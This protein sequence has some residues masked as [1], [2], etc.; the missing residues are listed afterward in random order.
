MEITK[1]ALE[2]RKKLIEIENELIE[3]DQKYKDWDQ[4]YK[5]AIKRIEICRAAIK[6]AIIENKLGPKNKD[7]IRLDDQLVKEWEQF[8][9]IELMLEAL[10]KSK[11]LLLH[12]K[13]FVVEAE[14]NL[15]RIEIISMVKSINRVIDSYYAYYENQ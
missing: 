2:Q 13:Y 14:V 1:I 3:V 12:L 6:I 11:G 15:L 10:V 5:D 4:R 7:V 9:E 8:N